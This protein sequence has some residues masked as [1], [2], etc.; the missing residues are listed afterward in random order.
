[1]GKAEGLPALRES[2]ERTYR[3]IHEEYL[4]VHRGETVR[5]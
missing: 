4:K 3:W 5:T 1:M 2:M